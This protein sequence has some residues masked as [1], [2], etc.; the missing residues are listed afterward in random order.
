[1]FL[2]LIGPELVLLT[3]GLQFIQARLVAMGLRK[4]DDAR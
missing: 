4:I 1:M 2:W 3:S